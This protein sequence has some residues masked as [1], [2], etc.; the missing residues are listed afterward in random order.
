MNVTNADRELLVPLKDGGWYTVSLTGQVRM[1]LG[2]DAYVDHSWLDHD[3]W[4]G[5]E[6]PKLWANCQLMKNGEATLFAI[7]R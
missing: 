7:T 4:A 1:R 2:G 6:S 3:L 5:A